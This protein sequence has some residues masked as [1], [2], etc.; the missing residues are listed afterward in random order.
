MYTKT[1]NLLLLSLTAPLVSAVG[2]ARVINNCDF[3]TFVW[4]DTR[5]VSLPN[6][7]SST[8]NWDEKMSNDLLSGGR[9]LKIRLEAREVGEMKS[10]IGR[11]QTNFAYFLD[12]DKVRYSLSDLY[13]DPFAGKK[14][15]LR[16]VGADCGVIEW[17]AGIS[18][19]AS[20]VQSCGSENDVV[21]E[22][23]AS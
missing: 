1:L 21:L 6:I 7:I 19:G 20:Q 22:L 4:G 23:C 17:A 14:L 8:S 15:R 5:N 18:T 10:D 11:P 2:Y 3:F 16:G 9:T 12:G 13:G